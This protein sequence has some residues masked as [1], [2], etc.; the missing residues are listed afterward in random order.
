MDNLFNQRFQAALSMALEKH[1]WQKRKGKA[2]PYFAHLMSV[3]ALV[4]ENGGSE[5]QAIAA[6]LHDAPEDQGGKDTL[7]EIRAAFGDQVAEIVDGCTD[8]YLKPKPEWKSRKESYLAKLPSEPETTQLVSLSDKVHNA[9]CIRRDLQLHGDKIWNDFNGG[10]EGTLWYYRSLAEIFDET[11]FT[12]LKNELRSLV[13]EI[14]TLA[15]FQE[16]RT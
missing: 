8:T 12:A 4:L 10:K 7:E 14:S 1:Q 9:R 5:D 11:P 16:G 6:L 15:N 13:E 3:C 2:T